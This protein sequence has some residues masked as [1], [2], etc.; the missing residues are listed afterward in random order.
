MANRLLLISP[1]RN[2]CA[3]IER[4]ARAVARQQRPPDVWLIV[5]DGSDDG[6]LEALRALELEIPCLRVLQAPADEKND[7]V[8][9]LGVA[10]EAVA[11]NWALSTAGAEDFT[12]VGKLDGDIELAEDHFMRLLAE[13]DHDPALGIV[14]CRLIEPAGSGW[15]PVGIPSYHVHGAVKLY[16]RPC[17]EAIGGVHE[18]LGWDT[19]DETYARMRGYVTRTFTDLVALHHRPCA[20]AGGRL[21]GRARHGECAYIVRYGLGWILLRSLKVAGARPIGLSGLAFLWGYLRAA[22]T[23]AARVED[24]SFKRFVRR[25][26]RLRLLGF[27]P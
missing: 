2:E 8:D 18:R 15:R 26:L 9:R 21:R 14:G 13:F 11:F 1:V 7:A 12:H 25:E 3:H 17:F 16:S 10:A 4:V 19:I 6:T 27:A 23:G 24:E 5:D 22:F 20:S